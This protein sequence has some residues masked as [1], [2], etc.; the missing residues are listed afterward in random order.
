[1]LLFL[2]FLAIRRLLRVFAGSSSVAALELENAVLRH[3]LTVL[4]RTAKRPPLRRRDRLLLAAAGG[5]AAA[6]S[7]VGI[8]GF[9]A[10]AFALAS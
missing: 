6:G 4:Q 5:A 2:V 10:D 3:Q 9:A 7:L 1:V 8:S